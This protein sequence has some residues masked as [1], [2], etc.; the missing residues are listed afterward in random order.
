M[1]KEVVGDSQ[2]FNAQPKVYTIVLNY[3]NY[4]DTVETLQSALMLDYMNNHLLLVENSTR[5]EIIERIHRFFPSLEIIENERNLGYAGGNNVG[6][7]CAMQRGAEYIFV[8]NNDVALQPDVLERLVF[9]MQSDRTAAACQ[10]LVTYYDDKETI[11]SAGTWLFLGYPRLFLKGKRKHGRGTEKPPFGLVGCALLFRAQSL[12]EIG[13]FDES[14]FLLQEETDWCM[15]AV[16]KGFG[17]LV[18]CDAVVHHKVSVTLGQFSKEYL[19]YIARNWLLVAKKYNGRKGY[20][21]VLLTELFTR[22]PYYLYQLARK[23][24]IA[25]MKYYYYGLRDG[26]QGV[27]GERDF[28]GL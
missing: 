23:N 6:I 14:L 28:D 16:K 26:L 13:L 27:S 21:Y 3:N 24:Q 18:V 10:P 22:I 8:I 12:Q 17:L 15:R 1:Q 4:S 2:E 19:Y 7:R 20:A 9:A 11:W 5:K 25:M